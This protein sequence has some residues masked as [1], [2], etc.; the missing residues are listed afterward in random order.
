M[1]F[2]IA[3]PSKPRSL[4]VATDTCKTGLT[5]STPFDTRR[6]W[7]LFSKT[8]I[9][10]LSINAILVGEDK[11]VTTVSTFRFG[12]FVIKGTL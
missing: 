10:V 3:I 7:P 1:L 8:N 6:T 4:S 11:P 9:L 2:R 5:C 12:S